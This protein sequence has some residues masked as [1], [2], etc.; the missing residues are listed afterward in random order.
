MILTGLFRE[1]L[2]LAYSNPVIERL[3]FASLELAVLAGLVGIGVHVARVKSARLIALLWLLVLAKPVVSLLVGAPVPLLALE[4]A[5]ND[6]PASRPSQPALDA[7]MPS[8]TY[9]AQNESAIATGNAPVNPDADARPAIPVGADV[10]ASQATAPRVIEPKAVTQEPEH[11][12]LALAPVTVLISLWLLGVAVFVC[13]SVHDRLSLRRLIRRAATPDRDLSAHYDQILAKESVRRAPCL[14]VTDELESPA[15][16]GCLAPTILVPRWLVAKRETNQ[17]DWALRHE[18]MHW[19]I[20][21]PLAGLVRELAQILFYFHPAVWWAGREWEV[22]AELACDRAL[23]E[24]DVDSRDYAEQLYGMLEEIRGRRRIAVK[25]GLFATRTQ[26]VRRIAALVGGPGQGAAHLSVPA[27]VALIV[28]SAATLCIG[29]TLTETTPVD[30]PAAD[31]A[32]I[33]AKASPR[34]SVRGDQTETRP[35]PPATVAAVDQAATG[36]Q[37]AAGTAAKQDVTYTFAG[38]VVDTDG[39]PLAGAKVSLSY[40]R[41]DNTPD[42]SLQGA[43]SDSRGG[44]EFSVKKSDLDPV[45]QKWR[46]DRVGV[47]AVK[48]GYGFDFLPA[49]FLDTTG[50][51]VDELPGTDRTIEKNWGKPRTVFTLVADDVPV[52]GRVIDLEGRGVADVKV[53]VVGAFVGIDGSLD[54][55]EAAASQ[56][57]ADYVTMWQH[58][59][60]LAEGYMEMGRFNRH[61][62]MGD[63]PPGRIYMTWQFLGG[64]RAPF[65]PVT[66]TNAEGRFTIKGLGRD[67]IAEFVLSAPGIETTQ[68]FLRSRPGKVLE[69]PVNRNGDFG[70]ETFQA[71][72]FTVVVGPGAKV[73]GRALDK[74]TGRPLVGVRVQST[75]QLYVRDVTDT[76]GRYRL[77]GLRPGA[78]NLV[79]TPPARS[80]HLAGG[81]ALKTTDLLKAIE[82][83]VV[84]TEG[85]MVRGRAIDSHTQKPVRGTA[86]YFAYQTNPHLK[87]TDSLSLRGRLASGFTMDAEG[88]FELPILPGQGFL[89]FRAGPDF[90]SGAG[91]DAIDCPT[92]SDPGNSKVFLTAPDWCIAS[93]FSLLTPLNPKPEEKELTVDVTLRSML[94]IPGRVLDPE[95]KPLADYLIDGA[96]RM[97]VWLKNEGEAFTVQGYSPEEKRWVMAWHPELNLVGYSVL[98]GEPPEK[99]EIKLRPAA[100]LTGRVLDAD[101]LP[102]KNAQI[103]GRAIEPGVEIGTPRNA[104]PLEDGRRQP[105]T[106]EDGRFRLRGIVPGLKYTVQIQRLKVPG[107]SVIFTDVTCEPGETRDLGDLQPKVE[108]VRGER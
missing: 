42:P 90:P 32:T 87:E 23:V 75:G 3:L 17:L 27:I 95:G 24:G 34:E 103:L 43:E 99:V 21:D 66:R 98:T 40:M 73:T 8:S 78:S 91:A 57:D 28:V 25:S 68:Q 63:T 41:L 48:E 83:D 54:A 30:A 94:N 9:D 72:E 51:F 2:W 47:V 97:T 5:R 74:A 35:S 46:W 106:D 107:R 10:A 102:L 70:A 58:I 61:G 44:F 88:R 26:I 37:N 12:S 67:R 53:E 77:E 85:I 93:A 100:T 19:R 52:S 104:L 96:R 76:E 33:A 56:K 6:Q 18:L 89:A 29:A 49:W 82:R 105:H 60:T 39:K 59:R 84:L 50:R 108:K 1:F 62:R 31:E 45:I 64:F 16:I 69:L 81:V 92:N 38:T 13:R 101:G 36:G 65:V 22:A 20:L 55:W 7:Q 86:E 11:K 79:V 80:R 71:N 4:L 14:K 15:L